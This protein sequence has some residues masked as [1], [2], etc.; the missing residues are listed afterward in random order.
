[1]EEFLTVVVQI[2]RNVD[3]HGHVVVAGTG[4]AGGALSAQAELA[5]AR[6]AGRD[7]HRG[8][9][10]DGGDLGHRA[11]DRVVEADAHVGVH[12]VAL[13]DEP[14]PVGGAALALHGYI[15]RL[16]LRLTA[17]AGL[18]NPP[19]V[20]VAVLLEAHRP[21]AAALGLASALEH[22]GEQIAQIPHLLAA[23]APASERIAAGRAA[24]A[25]RPRAAHAA[26]V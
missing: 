20:V 21:P 10:V 11:V 6:G 17:A 24:P 15:L 2:R 22:L 16:S 9:A 13:D 12:V 25:A 1:M 4:R 7:L 19:G 8:H 18:E 14:A 3:L 5:A 23:A 26:H